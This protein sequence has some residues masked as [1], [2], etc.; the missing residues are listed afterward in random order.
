MA[1]KQVIFAD[2][3]VSLTVQNELVRLDFAV[4][5][6]QVK[7]K[8]DQVKQRLEINSQLVIPLEAFIAAVDMQSR[9][10]RQ[11]A[12]SQQRSPRSDAVSPA[13]VKA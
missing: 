10:V 5:A 1:Y 13:E 11:L 3:L 6:G 7:D 2:R 4:N 8:D 12:E 9:L